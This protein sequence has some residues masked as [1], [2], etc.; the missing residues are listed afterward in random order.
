MSIESILERIAVAVEKITVCV[1]QEHSEL[2][3]SSPTLGKRSTKPEPTD[4][5]EAPTKAK[6]KRRTK[7][8]IEED[9]KKT[10]KTTAAPEQESDDDL[11]DSGEESEPAVTFQ[12]LWEE[13]RALV[14]EKGRDAGVKALEEVG[15]DR[16]KTVKEADYADLMRIMKEARNG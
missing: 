10:D 1:V 6:R 2:S 11:F 13:L 15:T 16:L 8:Q 14:R 9:K 7:A 3:G 12:D 5:A 4:E